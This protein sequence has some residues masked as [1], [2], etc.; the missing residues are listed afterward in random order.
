[1]PDEHDVVGQDHQGHVQRSCAAVGGDR[2]TVAVPGRKLLLEGGAVGPEG[3]AA[4][5]KRSKDVV[6]VDF[7]DGRPVPNASRRDSSFPTKDR[8]RI[9]HMRFPSF[10]LG[11]SLHIAELKLSAL[12]HPA[13]FN[14]H[15][16]LSALIATNSHYPL[17]F[18]Y[19]APRMSSRCDVRLTTE[20]ARV[21]IRLHI[22][23]RSVT[24]P[25]RVV[26]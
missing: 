8:E 20:P 13:V 26:G 23:R 24:V 1:M 21:P 22:R 11:F 5:P 14:R 6:A 12:A 19:Q 4:G 16:T 9:G 2:V 3:V 25:L 7:G 17:C 10:G 15:G 18:T